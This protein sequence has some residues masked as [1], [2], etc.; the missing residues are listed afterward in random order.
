MVE[1][2]VSAAESPRPSRRIA[3]AAALLL[4]VVVA[5]AVWWVRLAADPL[6]TVSALAAA[7]ENTRFHL[8]A[9][10]T[11]TDAANVFL[12]DETGVLGLRAPAGRALTPGDEVDIHGE[13]RRATVVRVLRR[14]A[15][16][17]YESVSLP[18]LQTV[19][20]GTAIATEGVVRTASA[21]TLGIWSNEVQLTAVVAGGAI[22]R[23]G[24][25]IDARVG[26]RGAVVVAGASPK[27][28]IAHSSDVRVIEPATAPRPI[29]SI[30]AL[31]RA[32]HQ[33]LH[34][35]RISG[36]I[37]DQGRR[38]SD[39]TA[40]VVLSDGSGFVPVET[41]DPA[42]CKPGEQVEAAGWPVS[43]SFSVIVQNAEI[44]R[45]AGV[46]AKRVEP[47]LE[48]ITSAS[49]VHALAPSE[50]A[51][52][53]PVLLRGVITYS[54]PRWESLMIQDS[55]SGIYVRAADLPSFP[56]VGDEVSLE[57]VSSP[58]G[59]APIIAQPHLRI[60]GKGRLPEP[61]HLTAEDAAS[62]AADCQWVE[63]EGAFRSENQDWGH[64]FFSVRTDLG[65]VRVEFPEQAWRG[66]PAALVGAVVRA[67]GAF[68]TL[69]NQYRQ[70][71][72]Y[73]LFVASPEQL[74]V[75]RPAPRDP[76]A[77]PLTPIRDLLNY[78]RGYSLRR[79]RTSGVVSMTRAGSTFI[80]DSTGGLEVRI[81]HAMFSR[82]VRVEAI[83]YPE[84]G[85][86][87]P[88][89]A[90]AT[91]RVAA[92]GRTALPAPIISPPDAL[93]GKY[94]NRL[95]R[96]EGE[97]LSA[98]TLPQGVALV[99]QSG[100]VTWNAE[101]DA[102]PGGLRRLPAEW[103]PGTR[104]RV[105]GV[106]SVRMDASQIEDWKGMAPSSFRLLLS[107]PEDVAVVR[108][109]SWWTMQRTLSAL[110]IMALVILAALAWVWTLRGRV[111]RQTAEL[112]EAR[113]HAE[114]ANR[115][116]SEFLANMSHEIRTPM[117]GI[118][119]MTE[120]ALSTELSPEQREFLS[121]AKSSADALLV[122]LNDIL[123]FSK[124]DAGKIALDP[125]P[126]NLPEAVGDAVKSVAIVAHRKGLELSY[127][128]APG[129]P[130]WVVGDYTR[131][132]QVI[133]N[134]VGN[135]I[136][137]TERGEVAVEIAAAEA[138][139]GVPQ[140]HF[141]VRDTGIGIRADR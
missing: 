129:V 102:A 12:R 77:I 37:A 49:A 78:S 104:V 140:I 50:A 103:R 21:N 99:M 68:G 53:H 44:H 62:G 54:D 63:L 138:I 70:L 39:G 28:V 72:G 112:V 79:V 25:L 23:P 127:R 8:R 57:G 100:A 7:P 98:T 93:T 33:P 56:A 123:D 26:V 59:F 2:G 36:M 118:I 114:R 139:D 115:A 34:R 116:K 92:N 24:S 64:V 119:G 75:L 96:M 130:A 76:S 6:T 121:M 35:V 74:T 38:A 106:C 29:E 117:N 9:T 19:R 124:I 51:R 137:F 131:L 45:A 83:G 16:L 65:R 66:D 30:G 22:D 1:T 126:F 10:V 41:A 135:A 91:L 85:E 67:R 71:I 84:P 80:E 90:D 32:P 46:A 81:P 95:V 122:I 132:R 101:M 136:K 17:R 134:L 111:R 107:S 87:T 18:A 86:Y 94:D 133:L 105:T 43:S 3:I 110:G 141:S 61:A 113:E 15:P 27:L 58:G 47:G 40:I 42:E 69:F 120:L 48:T 128:V 73:R 109:A 55:S 97:L 89:L 108:A 11:G 52:K 14:Q 125:A 88:L 13:A 82:G 31:I 60:L 20:E 5:G 4:L